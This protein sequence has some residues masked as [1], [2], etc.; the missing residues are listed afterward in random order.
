MGH[1]LFL[2]PALKGWIPNIRQW[3]YTH[4][5]Q[6]LATADFVPQSEALGTHRKQGFCIQQPRCWP[7]LIWCPALKVGTP[8]TAGSCSHQVPFLA[9]SDFVA[10]SKALGTPKTTRVMYAL[11]PIVC[12]C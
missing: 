7:L 4:S 1:H 5:A 9:I 10:C 12:H 6:S 8:K 11:G 3:L 2:S